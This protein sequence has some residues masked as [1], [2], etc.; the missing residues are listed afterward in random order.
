MRDF[1]YVSNMNGVDWKA[2]HD[3]YAPLVQYVRHRDDLTY[4]IGEMISELNN[5]HTYITSGE[6]LRA[7]KIPLGLLGAKLS[8]HES[9]YFRIDKILEG[10]SWSKELR[11][12]LNDLNVDAKEGEFILAIDGRSVKD[13]DDIYKLLVYKANKEVM[14]TINSVPKMEGSRNVIVVPINDESQLYY[15]NWVQNNVKKVSEATNGEVGY[16]HIPDMGTEGLNNFAEYFYPQ[17]NKKALIIDD[18]GNSGGNVSPMIIERLR[19]ELTCSK[20]SR[21]VEEPYPIPTEMILGP[22]VLLIDHYSASDGDVFAYAFKKLKLGTLIGTRTWGGV[23]GISGTL[24]FL[25]GTELRKPQYATYSSDSSK[26]IVEGYG[27][28]PDILI[29]NDPSREYYGKD[30]QLDKAIEVIKEQLKNYKGLPPIPPAPDRS[31]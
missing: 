19:R 2:M 16:L 26:W 5:S 4:L 11:S 25:D 8:K 15:Y 20:M 3:K 28:D 7:E 1:F 9:G 22:K 14:L 31:K 29:D 24:P 23:V 17:L 13:V 6:K 27:V 10:A 21:N 30:D 18:R 12:P